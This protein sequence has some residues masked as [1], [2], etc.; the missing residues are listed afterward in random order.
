MANNNNS[1][2]EAL[3]SYKNDKNLSYDQLASLVGNKETAPKISNA[4][5]TYAELGSDFEERTRAKLALQVMQRMDLQ[6]SSGAGWGALGKDDKNIP[7]LAYEVVDRLR[8]GFREPGKY[9]TQYI[10]QD[11]ITVY[12]PGPKKPLTDLSQIK[13]GTLNSGRIAT[14]Y[15]GEG[16]TVVEMKVG[17]NGP[18]FSS[19]VYRDWETDRKS[20]E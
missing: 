13:P 17:E 10:G 6:N 18:T 3:L 19:W 9:E 11:E 15:A 2:Y 12:V 16:K 20:V 5:K 4:L 8:E 7:K 14:T 1:D